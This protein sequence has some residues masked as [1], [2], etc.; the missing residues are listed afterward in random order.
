MKNET[1]LR[2][3]NFELSRIEALRKIS[4]S[5]HHL[6]EVSCNYG[7]TPRQETREKNLL[8]KAETL[9]AEIG[10]KIYHQGDPRGC[11]LYLLSED[12]NVN[13]YSSG[14]ALV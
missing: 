14:I 8:K 5:L 4:R 11:A 9:A 6:A 3:L 1:E 7:L 13:N 10:L 12:M 2:N